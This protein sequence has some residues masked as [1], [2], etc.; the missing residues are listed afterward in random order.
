[1]LKNGPFTCHL[2]LLVKYGFPID[3]DRDSTICHDMVNHNSVIQY[4]NHMLHY[5]KEEVKHGA[6]AGPFTDPPINSLHV[7]PVITR[8][9]SSSEY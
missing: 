2:P 8:D 9:K 7:N 4:P 3:F 5:L 1:M 6:I